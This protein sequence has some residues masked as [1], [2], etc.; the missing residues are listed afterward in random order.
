MVM[1]GFGQDNKQITAYQMFW[2]CGVG[3][4][5]MKIK[6]DL[7]KNAYK[8]YNIETAICFGLDILLFI[9]LSI[10]LY[11][12]MHENPMAFALIPAG[13][14]IGYF[15]HYRLFIL[16]RVELMRNEY[17][18]QQLKIEDFYVEWWNFTWNI[19]NDPFNT[20]N[21]VNMVYPKEKN[22]ER[23]KL[24]CTD[25]NGNKIKL[26]IV[27]SAKKRDLLRKI[28]NNF[29]DKYIPVYYGKR[30]KIVVF[31]DTSNVKGE[32]KYLFDIDRLNYML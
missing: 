1:H 29:A 23:Y 7:I 26:R 4:C 6:R 13:L 9:I 25:K 19:S 22:V 30:T 3:M 21:L 10:A 32:Q 24:V 17:P 18:V 16:S 31:F 14:L 12:L 11:F 28:C 8:P 2:I 15:I 20:A 27:A 5:F